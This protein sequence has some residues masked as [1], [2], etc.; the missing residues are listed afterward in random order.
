VP[1]RI[2]VTIDGPTARLLSLA[3]GVQ[4]AEMLP[5]ESG[6]TLAGIARGIRSLAEAREPGLAVLVLDDLEAFA[7]D[8]E[9]DTPALATVIHAHVGRLRSAFRSM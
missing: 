6:K 3:R 8:A 9:A 1:G 7:K 2:P 5:K 4:A